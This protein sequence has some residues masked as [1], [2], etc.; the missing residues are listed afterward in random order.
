MPFPLSR[1]FLAARGI[2]VLPRNIRTHA[3]HLVNHANP[4]NAEFRRKYNLEDISE[5]SEINIEGLYK[6]LGKISREEERIREM[7]ESGLT[8]QHVTNSNEEVER[9]V[10]LSI[11][12]KQRRGLA[13]KEP[14][15]G[16]AAGNDNVFF[17]VGLGD[18]T[19]LL[20]RNSGHSGHV[21]T[22][23]LQGMMRDYPDLFAGFFV[24][25]KLGGYGKQT[26]SQPLIMGD[27][28]F[29]FFNRQNRTR[30]YCY[31]R[32]DGKSDSKEVKMEDE[33][34]CGSD[35]L[36]GISGIFLEH[37]RLIGGKYQE[38]LCKIMMDDRISDNKKLQKLS[39][40]MR[41]IMPGE[42]YPEGKLPGQLLLDKSNPHI[43]VKSLREEAVLQY[44][45]RDP[46][47]FE[48]IHE[49][50]EALKNSD[51][52]VLKHLLD[53]RKISPPLL[54]YV[55]SK[56]VGNN[57][58]NRKLT[59]EFLV[60]H[61]ASSQ[62]EL[63]QGIYCMAAAAGDVEMMGILSSLVF[64]DAEEP[65]I[66]L[67]P[68]P[69]GKHNVHGK[70]DTLSEVCYSGKEEVL[71]ILIQ[72]GAVVSGS[73]GYN[74]LCLIA[75]NV[76]E[77]SRR[78]FGNIDVD[79]QLRMCSLLIAHGA[80][81]N[82]AKSSFN[83]TPLM[84]FAEAGSEAGIKMLVDA[85]ANVNER[86]TFLQNHV[87]GGSFK[88]SP[89]NGYT[90]LHFLM[91]AEEISPEIKLKIMSYLIERGADV[92]MRAN[93]GDTAYSL[94]LANRNY[95]IAQLLKSKYGA[96]TKIEK[97]PYENKKVVVA[98]LM[99]TDAQGRKCVIL[100]RKSG[101]SGAP[102]KSYFFPGGFQDPSDKD[103]IAAAVR[104]VKEE[105]YFD[106]RLAAEPQ[107]IFKSK[108]VGKDYKIGA[109]GQSMDCEVNYVLLDVG[110]IAD[111]KLHGRGDLHNPALIPL[112]EVKTDPVADISQRNYVII[113]GKLCFINPSNGLIIEALRDNEL[114]PN[115]LKTLEDLSNIELNGDG[116]LFEAV[117]QNNIE[118]IDFLLAMGASP[119][120]HSEHYP[121]PVLLAAK[122]GRLDIVKKLVAAGAQINVLGKASDK[123]PYY[124]GVLEVAVLNGDM[125]LIDYLLPLSLE[126]EVKESLAFAFEVAARTGNVEIAKKLIEHAKADVNQKGLRYPL[127][128][129]AKNGHKDMVL[130]LLAHGADVDLCDKSPA[131]VGVVQPSAI[132]AAQ[133]NGHR[134]I[135]SILIAN[136]KNINRHKVACDQNL[137]REVINPLYAAIKYGQDE[138]AEQILKKTNIDLN[139][140]KS[141]PFAD[142]EAESILSY[143]VLMRRPQIAAQ[144]R[145]RMI[146]NHAASELKIDSLTID[147]KIEPDE[148][149]WAAILVLLDD[150][151]KAQILADKTS[152]NLRFD[153]QAQ[154]YY[155][156]LDK[157]RLGDFMEN[158]GELYDGLVYA[159]LSGLQNPRGQKLAVRGKGAAQPGWSDL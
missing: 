13:V 152:A 99:G 85:G 28:K 81:V 64:S 105:T 50:S 69:N 32:P 31:L 53:Q 125:E 82:A 143:A 100:G 65:Q 128:E 1:A 27:T 111:L 127:L 121:V 95:E 49:A 61:G 79:S 51:I 33:I 88:V 4:P 38:D 134:E 115:N 14:D 40:A 148:R 110:N 87:L 106:L 25:G 136:C 153:E 158:G 29:R 7:I 114:T 155:V 56:L 120:P 12:E 86:Y 93:N 147:I 133:E 119:N 108:E 94:A 22:V 137:W 52:Y 20:T 78:H 104:K 6:R 45:P 46:D 117:K 139:D 68:D 112:E 140:R 83:K 144:I 48:F 126:D 102:G 132:L 75:Q 116:L 159:N 91:V 109:H 141:D 57:Y 101:K 146:A 138:I 135:A 2:G 15:I 11:R 113:G 9:G 142:S 149:G 30:V 96:D 10:L 74:L 62:D 58:R 44:Q 72:D 23:S 92:N 54:T 151:E 67:K 37:L 130:L 42:I 60:K 5:V 26:A 73:K 77:V 90:A 131:L 47:F 59:A 129:A 34:F 156:Q 17:T 21:V 19:N 124:H 97:S 41:Y 122:M 84:S 3:A 89:Q 63:G 36:E 154:K 123:S 71:R 16:S 35:V 55:L 24:S 80:K 18:S 118:K 43:S 107:I 98:V 66:K 76:E 39:R 8:A 103:V 157:G 145:Q 70:F 150:K